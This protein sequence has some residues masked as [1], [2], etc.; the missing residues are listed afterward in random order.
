MQEK[1]NLLHYI[2]SE[3]FVCFIGAKR[4]MMSHLA[5]QLHDKHCKP[6]LRMSTTFRDLVI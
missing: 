1:N 4:D 2:Q 3:W 5:R 6:T